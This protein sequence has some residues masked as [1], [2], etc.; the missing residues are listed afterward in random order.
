[1][2]ENTLQGILSPHST[3]HIPRELLLRNI[4]EGFLQERPERLDG[5]DEGALGGGVGR[6]HRGAE[7]HHVEMRILA[8]DDGA[9]QSGMIDLDDTILAKQILVFLQEQV[10]DL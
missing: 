6:L 9:L 2:A 4:L 8:K 7:A 5:S 10:Q 1:M 3:F